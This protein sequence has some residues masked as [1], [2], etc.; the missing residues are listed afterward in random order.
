LTCNDRHIPNGRGNLIIK[1][2]KALRLR[3]GVNKGAQMH[4]EK[5]IPSPG[6]LGGG[7]SNAAVTLIGLSKLWRID[8]SPND[9]RSIAA[10]LGSDVPFFLT[11]GTAIATGRGETLH[12][13]DDIVE[14]N[15]LIVTPGLSVSTRDA[16]AG[17]NAARLTK[18]AQKR[19]LRV[20]RLEAGS[21]DLHQT[22]LKNDFEAL[23]FSA[24]PEIRRVKET[25]SDLGAINAAMSGSGAS[26][27]AVFDKKETR[28]A[29]IE[30][31]GHEPTWRKF[32]VAT[33]SRSEYREALRC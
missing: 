9:L 26:V 3:T 21:L 29:A 28:Q 15:I 7:S 2:A 17:L 8:V 27:Y 1:A 12:P 10:D 23:L 33:I 13:I 4:L 32:V 6:G 19:I 20:C 31:L 24:H 11:G 30:A 22:V 16:Y 25:L 18:E 5:R 14:E